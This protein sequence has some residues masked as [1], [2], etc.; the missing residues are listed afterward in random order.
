MSISEAEIGVVQGERNLS[1]SYRLRGLATDDEIAGT[2][3]TQ[4]PSGF[5]ADFTIEGVGIG[6]FENTSACFF[7]CFR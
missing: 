3:Q 1:R 6:E 4:F 7:A 2:K 5:T